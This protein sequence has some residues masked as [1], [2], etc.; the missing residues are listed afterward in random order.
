MAEVGLVIMFPMCYR[1][2]CVG[3]VARG[4]TDVERC[5]YI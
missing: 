3:S 2:N 5:G 1:A 4:H